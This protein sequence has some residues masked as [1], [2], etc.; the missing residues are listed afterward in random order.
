MLNCPTILTFEHAVLSP[1]FYVLSICPSRL[2][3]FLHFQWKQNN[4]ILV[5]QGSCV[6]GRRSSCRCL[7]K[8]T[9]IAF[10][11]NIW[12]RTKEEDPSLFPSLIESFSTT[13]MRTDLLFCVPI[14]FHPEMQSFEPRHNPLRYRFFY[15]SMYIT[16]Y[17]GH[18]SIGKQPGFAEGSGGLHFH[19]RRSRLRSFEWIRSFCA[20]SSSCHIQ[21][22]TTG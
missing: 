7:W 15:C 4:L 19:P 12:T 2:S 20:I 18:S 8:K 6:T 22:F 3:M 21:A 17:K 1:L 11:F 14:I 9:T 10:K 13:R 5:S 16:D